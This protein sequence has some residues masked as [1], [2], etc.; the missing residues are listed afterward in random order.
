MKVIGYG[1]FLNR[2]SFEKT[3]PGREAKQVWVEGF[4]RVFNLIPSRL[5]LYK[6]E[7]DQTHRTVLN[8]EIAEGKRLNA[9]VFEVDEDEFSLLKIR[10]RSYNPRKIKFLDFKTGKEEGEAYMFIG[11]SKLFGEEII[12]NSLL[13]I[14]PYLKKCRDGARTQGEDF[15]EAWL[16]NTYLGDGRTVREYLS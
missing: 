11:K 14:T 13:P 2:N 8:T 16:D 9:V 4:R 7:I 15:Y 5:N 12:N 1:S 3:L 6:D 10:E